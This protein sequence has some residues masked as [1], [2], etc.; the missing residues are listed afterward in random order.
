MVAAARLSLLLLGCVGLLWP[1]GKFCHLGGSQFYS[2][3]GHEPWSPLAGEAGSP[4]P[5]HGS[6][7]A[8]ARYID[9]C[10]KGWYYYKLSCFKYFSQLQSWDEAEVRLLG[11]RGGWGTPSAGNALALMALP[12]EAVPGQLCRCP[13]GLGGGA[14]GSSHP[15]EGHLLLPACAARLARPPL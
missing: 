3:A 15:A 4:I 10:P 13:P 5:P 7:S 8:G 14:P 12:V 1:T 6:P 2:V 11:Y 9:Y